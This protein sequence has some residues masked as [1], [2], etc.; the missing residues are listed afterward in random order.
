MEAI[1]QSRSSLVRRKYHLQGSRTETQNPALATTVD[2][3][4]YLTES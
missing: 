2:L 4:M 1:M 3:D